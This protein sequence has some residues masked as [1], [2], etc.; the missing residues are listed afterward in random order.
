MQERLGFPVEVPQLDTE[1]VLLS[2]VYEEV[3][4]ISHVAFVE[5]EAELQ[6]LGDCPLPTEEWKGAEVLLDEVCRRF[7][8]RVVRAFV[9]EMALAVLDK[10]P[11]KKSPVERMLNRFGFVRE[12]H[13]QLTAFTRV[14]GRK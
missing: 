12:D 11:Q 10:H 2:L 5:A 13:T 3:G 7:K 8:L 1:P 6:T 14:Q 9:P 4:V